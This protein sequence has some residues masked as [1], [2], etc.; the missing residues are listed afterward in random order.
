M[1]LVEF[2]LAPEGQYLLAHE[3]GYAAA[4]WVKEHSKELNVD[5]LRMV[6]AG[7]SVGGL[8]A[9]TIAMMAHE[10]GGPKFI[11]QLLFY[12]VADANFNTPSYKQFADG[13][14]LTKPAMDWFWDAYVPNKADRTKPL[15][16]PLHAS[17]DQLKIC[18]LP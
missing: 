4:Q 3:Q 9:T 1:V 12:P 7:D 13:A 10:R 2:T 17:L 14:W 6:I 8:M 11:M 15:A 5:S 18:L 16:A